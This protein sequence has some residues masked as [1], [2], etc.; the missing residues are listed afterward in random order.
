[1]APGRVSDVLSALPVQALRL[2]ASIVN[3]LRDVGIEPIAQLATKP[4]GSLRTRFGAEVLLRMDQALGAASE[5]LIALVPPEVPRSKMCFAEPVGDP[6]D[7]QRII[8]IYA[9]A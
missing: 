8:A 1:M 9:R 6:E 7:L 4:R 3:G 5:V 2:H